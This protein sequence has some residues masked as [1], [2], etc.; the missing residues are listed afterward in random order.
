MQTVLS[1]SYNHFRSLLTAL[2]LYALYLHDVFKDLQ[3]FTNT[4]CCMSAGVLQ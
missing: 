3:Y 1:D 4:L 2:I